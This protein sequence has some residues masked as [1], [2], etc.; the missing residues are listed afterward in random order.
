[1]SENLRES[2]HMAGYP[3]LTNTI[4]PPGVIEVYPHPALVELGFNTTAVQSVAD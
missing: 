4:A 2:F 1:M 3:L